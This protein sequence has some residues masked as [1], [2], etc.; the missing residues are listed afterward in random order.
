MNA[1]IHI[2]PITRIEGHASVKIFLDEKGEVKKTRLLIHSLRGFEKFVQGRP[3]E[4]IPRIVTRICGICPW[5]HHLAASKAIDNCFDIR[6]PLA[7][8]LL[9]ELCHLLAHIGDKILHFFF[10]ASPDFLIGPEKSHYSVRNIIGIAKS[11]PAL[12][13]K[14]ARMRQLVHEML[15]SFTGRSIHPVASVVGGFSKPMLEEERK[16]LLKAASKLLDF[17][18][19]SLE[20]AKKDIFGP[21]QDLFENLGTIETGFLGMVDNSGNLELYNGNL[22]LMSKDGEVIDFSPEEYESYI[23]ENVVPWSYSKVPYA[24]IWG[25]GLSLKIDDPKG[26]YRVNSLARINVVERIS[27]PHAQEALEEFRNR[28]GRPVQNTLL[29][30]WARLIELI[31][32]SER[33]IQILNKKEI[34]DPNVRKKAEPKAGRGIGCVEAPRGTLIHDYTTDKDGCIVKANLIVGTTHNTAAM[35]LS[36]EQAARSFIKKGYIDEEIINRIEM[37]VR[38]YDP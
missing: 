27:T 3:A 24:K 29:Y 4:E 5:M 26:V 16:E 7:G 12:T 20:F 21:N 9:R 33:V 34:T 35:N 6:P 17:A 11:F 30:H 28:F 14:V 10:L 19:F 13:S 2:N 22:R 32:A 37:A 18:L 25:K 15:E 36:V 1:N 38:A 8:N 31:Y 23:E